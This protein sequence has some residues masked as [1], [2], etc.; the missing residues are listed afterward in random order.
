M[1]LPPVGQAPLDT[2]EQIAN[3]IDGPPVRQDAFSIEELL[4]READHFRSRALHPR[5][6][7]LQPC[8]ERRWKAEGELLF[9][10]RVPHGALHCN[11]LQY[12]CRA[13]MLSPILSA[14][15]VRAHRC[16]VRG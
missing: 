4:E 5:G 16:S 6:D 8:C 15:A 3:Q 13:T 12:N 14:H 10:R 9:H 7:S 2:A 11:S 1:P